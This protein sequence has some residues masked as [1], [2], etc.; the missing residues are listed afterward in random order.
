MPLEYLDVPFEVKATDIKEDGTFSGYGSLFD[1]KLDAHRD[2]VSPGAFLDTLTK[3]G[4]NGTGV[5]MLW[6]HRPDKIPGVW[7]ALREDKKGLFSEGRLAL[8][9]TLGKDIYEIMK[10]GAELGTFRLSQSIG[11]DAIEYEVDEKKKI[12]DLKKVDLW[13]L[14]ICTFPA[15]LGATVTTVKSIEDARTER[16]LE[17]VLRESGLSKSVAQYV[18]KLCKPSLREAGDGNLKPCMLSGIL[19]GLREVNTDLDRFIEVKTTGLNGILS[20]LIEANY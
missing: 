5:A 10:L 12:R 3:G 6:Q 2:L 15:K 9:T 17:A 11:Y 13:E 1:R 19:D 20:S 18:V 7:S 16:E 14:S 4:R 8:N